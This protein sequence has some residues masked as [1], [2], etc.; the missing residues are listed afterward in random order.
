M[1]LS[2]S[3]LNEGKQYAHNVRT[4]LRKLAGFSKTK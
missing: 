1:A 4:G 3:E 2:L